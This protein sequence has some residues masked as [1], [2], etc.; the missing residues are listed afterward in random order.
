MPKFRDK[1]ESTRVEDASFYEIILAVD[2]AFLTKEQQKKFSKFLES[3]LSEPIDELGAQ[4]KYH[5]R[6]DR[7]LW[8]IE[9]HYQ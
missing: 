5:W 8:I 1:F 4:L 9:A 6:E 3:T 7:G 2:Y